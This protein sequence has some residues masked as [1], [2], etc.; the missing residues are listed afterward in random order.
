MKTY[1]RQI[2]IFHVNND[3][4]NFKIEAVKERQNISM[5]SA[6]NQNWS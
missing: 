5:F 2:K 1:K 6:K 4:E 3:Y